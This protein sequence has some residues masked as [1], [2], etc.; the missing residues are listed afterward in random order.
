M[1]GKLGSF[2]KDPGRKNAVFLKV[3]IKKIIL[4]LLLLGQCPCTILDV[5]ADTN[6]SNKIEQ[7]KKEKFN[8]S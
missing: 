1:S 5:K 7:V 2:L 8:G 4:Q 6:K 3:K